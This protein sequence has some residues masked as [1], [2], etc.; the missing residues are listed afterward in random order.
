MI[1]HTERSQSLAEFFPRRARRVSER[2]PLRSLRTPPREVKIRARSANKQCRKLNASR[3][4]TAESR[5]VLSAL[6][7]KSIRAEPSALFAY[8]QREANIR[9]GSAN[10][11]CRI[12][13]ASRRATAESRRVLS[14]L[15]AKSIR[16]EPSA[17]FAYPQREANIRAGS[18][19]DPCRILDASRRVT[20]ESCRVLSALSAKSIRAELSALFA[21]PQREVK[22]R[23]DSANKQY[24]ILDASRRATVESRRVL[25]ALSAK[26]I[27]VESSALFAYPQR[28]VKIRADSANNQCRILD[29]SRRATAEYR[30]VFVFAR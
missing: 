23:A 1:P 12:L 24:R 6:S 26:S 10:D 11:P 22:I 8:P 27:R 16:A 18:A 29:A 5:R 3:R 25:S 21:Y 9:A 13:N 20:A 15:S 2:S 28:E 14:A 17:L 19:N 4:A 7:A 30:R